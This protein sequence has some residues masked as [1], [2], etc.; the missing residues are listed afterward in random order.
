[1]KIW[2]ILSPKV[3]TSEERPDNLTS[4][5]QAKVKVTQL[6][7]SGT[8]LRAYCGISKPKYPIIPGRFAVGVV[9]EVGE[10]CVKVEKNT[11][12][13][14]HD[15]I[16]CGACNACLNGNEEHCS[17]T[18][19]AGLNSEGYMRDFVVTDESN[20]T[21]LPSSV[22]D[23]EALFAGIVAMGEM[24]ISRLTLT[25]GS[26]VAV[27]GAGEVGN[28]LSQL[29][30]YHQAVPILID[31][32]E[33]KLKIAT[34]CGIYYTIPLN[35]EMQSSVERITGGRLSCASVHCSYCDIDPSM[36][37]YV[38]AN[39]GNVVY[40]GFS[41]PEQIVQLKPALDKQLILSSVSND[42]S[43]IESAINLILNKAITIAPFHLQPHAISETSE[44]FRQA[45]EKAEKGV[46]VPVSIL[47]M[48]S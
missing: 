18:K 4:A 12:V 42:Y 35:E 45:A 38:T 47:N 43:Y 1:M 15:A 7:L 41:F 13:F 2:K 48:L 17:N 14:I 31:S 9:S 24:I 44:L 33:E 19:I 20:L 27:F 36:P 23:T 29:L 34:Q 16:P 11:R 28:I 5:T 3:L 30:I 21:P 40:T 22:S 6:L 26:H 39:G 32:N 8:E 25:K 10:G 37:F 46:S